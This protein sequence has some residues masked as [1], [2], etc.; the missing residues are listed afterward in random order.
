MQSKPISELAVD[1]EKLE[2]TLRLEEVKTAAKEAAKII[3]RDAERR[4]HGSIRDSFLMRLDRGATI[5]SIEIKIG[6][7]KQHWY[8]RFFD[9]GT[10]PHTITVKKSSVL[11]NRREGLFFGRTV[12]H[13]GMR[14]I[15]LLAGAIDA[16]GKEA[17]DHFNARL[18]GFVMESFG[19]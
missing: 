4:A 7:D 3:Q 18:R 1:F 11:V 16:V 5:D 6:T 2:R 15:P 13:P 8:A 14:K 10:K 9:T 17:A 12:K 19:N